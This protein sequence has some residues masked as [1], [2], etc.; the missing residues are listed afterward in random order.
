MA[1]P[2][3]IA[4]RLEMLEAQ[5][6]G[7]ASDDGA[8][9]LRWL[10]LPDE[11]SMVEAFVFRENE[12]DACVTADLFIRFD[13]AFEH[14]SGHGYALC[15]TFLAAY[16]EARPA[17][18]KEGL[19]ASFVPPALPE[20]DDIG[21]FVKLLDAYFQHQA[22][23]VERVVAFLHP[24][25]VSDSG[26]YQQWLQRLTH[27]CPAHV[28]VLVIDDA[29]GPALEALANV[30][31]VRVTTT[32]CNLDMQGALEAMASDESDGSPGAKFREMFVQLAGMTKQGNLE[33]AAPLAQVATAFAVTMQCPH[34]AAGVQLLLA[35]MYVNAQAPHDALRC[36][37]EV[38]RLGEATY[39]IGESTPNEAA[40]PAEDVE[41]K[42]DADSEGEDEQPEP[43][44]AQGATEL[45][46]DVAK[47]Y[48]LRLRRDARFGQGAVLISQ[49]AWEL[50]AKVYLEAAA[51]SKQLKEPLGELDGMRLASLCYEQQGKR[52][53]AWQCGMKGLE[54][55]GAMDEETRR[56][57][58]LGYLGESMLRMTEASSHRAYREPIRKHMDELLGPDWRER[59][60]KPPEAA[61]A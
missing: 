43:E 35:S 29:V 54:V 15:K 59:L 25:A 47:V 61:T 31:P 60:Q 2:N 24:D 20:R 9:L 19:D 22:G 55:G 32:P 44:P 53:E 8:R 26:A 30:E 52:E 28:R 51:L 57:S 14:P 56:S 27:A 16:D 36:Y 18:E 6:A 23:E 10:C 33:G 13:D 17:L 12:P 4:L 5:W 50:G 21:A 39:A 42:A 37:T 3:P 46:G 11:T 1:P 58:T 7:F 40:A 48:G 49:H 38:D 45:R 41:Q 34:L